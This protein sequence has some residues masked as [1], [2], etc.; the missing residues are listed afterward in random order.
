MIN[1]QNDIINQAKTL[2]TEKR[3]VILK[4]LGIS[5]ETGQILRK[6]LI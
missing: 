4:S 5:G 3:K 1:N 2:T 6:D